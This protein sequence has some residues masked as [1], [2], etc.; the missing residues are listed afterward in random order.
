MFKFLLAGV[1]L[2]CLAGCTSFNQVAPPT[3]I[4][5]ATST[6][7]TA[8]SSV[9][10]LQFSAGKIQT[11]VPTKEN[12]KF[13]LTQW[14]V[15][16]LSSVDDLPYAETPQVFFVD[17]FLAGKPD[18][19]SPFGFLNVNNIIPDILGR[20]L[21]N[22][23][24]RQLLELGVRQVEGGG[25]LSPIWGEIQ[26]TTTSAY[27]WRAFDQLV[28]TYQ[29]QN[30]Y[31]VPWIVSANA[32]DY[33]SCQR[34]VI[35]AGSLPP[36]V[37]PCNLNNYKKFVSAL[38]ERYDKDG[39][40]DA[41]NLRWG[42]RD[43]VIGNE[44][45]LAKFWQDSP[46]NFAK[47]VFAA[48]QAIK[49]ADPTARVHVGA[50]AGFIS[51]LLPAKEVMPPE[52]K[53]EID[54][55]QAGQAGWWWEFFAEL[56]KQSATPLDLWFDQHFFGKAG[57]YEKL[58]ILVS[59]W[60]N[61]LQ[62][63]GYPEAKLWSTEMGTFA[64]EVQFL[65]NQTEGGQTIW[66]SEKQQADELVKRYVF[67]L[68]VGLQK[69]FWSCLRSDQT[70]PGMFNKMGLV[71]QTGDKTLAFGALMQLTDF[72]NGGQLKVERLL[73]GQAN[74]YVFLVQRGLDKLYIFWQEVSPAESFGQNKA[75]ACDFNNDQIID[76]IEKA[77]C[78]K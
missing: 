2:V 17:N 15:K 66:Q 73:S 1:S 44:P 64:G 57:E 60:K 16:D 67:G 13:L 26:K 58:G 8:T 21:N 23:Y 63:Q 28:A 71:N 75:I 37:L 32:A 43:W 31:Y 46:A 78:L 5:L 3:I 56:K 76:E 59:A 70:Q 42:Q 4:N 10:V 27:N 9:A 30:L 65:S 54:T 36:L 49:A 52:F 53:D 39:Q 62:A 45:D 6:A 20:E 51:S 12:N 77:K 22:S 55:R 72:L 18:Q 38:V 35:K 69:I 48:Y 11:L 19:Y 74:H 25:R 61:I 50:N 47:L 14:L 68:S 40:A 41:P 33:R 24:Q 7:T 29:Q 34:E